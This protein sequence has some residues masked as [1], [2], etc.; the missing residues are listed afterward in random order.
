MHRAELK[1]LVVALRKSGYSYSLIARKTNLSKSTLSGWLTDIEY[2][3]NKETLELL[4]KARA[5]SSESKARIRRASIAQAQQEASKE[6]RSL[7]KKDLFM[8]GLGLYLGEG[9]KTMNQVRIVNA[10]PNVIRLMV[11]WFKSLG[12]KTNQ[13]APRLHLYPDS[14]LEKSLQFWSQMTTIPDTQFMRPLIDR[15]TDKK[16]KKQGKLPYGTLH[17]GV[18]SNGRKEFGAFF[19]R[20]IQAWNNQVLK[21]ADDKAGLVQW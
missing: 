14:D 10:D 6:I 17:L 12:V 1:E 9:S 2:T 16:A 15:R 19:A 7:S 3:P 11:C 13:F 21:K 20:K 18:R 4:G 5:A 8:F